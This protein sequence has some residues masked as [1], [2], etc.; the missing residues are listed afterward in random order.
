[1][2]FRWRLRTLMVLI[3]VTAVGF[4]AYAKMHSGWR[5]ELACLTDMASQ[6]DYGPWGTG[7]FTVTAPLGIRTLLPA[8]CQT[9]G[10]PRRLDQ[11]VVEIS[12]WIGPTE[13][14]IRLASE[15]PHLRRITITS[16]SKSQAS[17]NLPENLALLQS[18]R[19]DIKVDYEP[20][21]QTMS[22]PMEPVAQGR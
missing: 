6:S 21:Y 4:A 16:P 17:S 5:K 15:L 13:D 20:M 7:F 18:L 14:Q 9:R 1:M 19:P 10:Y 22:A 3:C 11:R 8:S 12:F 2:V